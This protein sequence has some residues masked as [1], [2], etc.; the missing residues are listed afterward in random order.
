MKKVKILFVISIIFILA[1]LLC[2][3][4]CD[5]G[6]HIWYIVRVKHDVEYANGQTI[7]T[8]T[9]ANVHEGQPQG[10]HNGNVNITFYEDGTVVFNPLD[11]DEELHGTYTLKHNGFFK[12]TNFTITF[13]NGEKTTNGKAA[14]YYGGSDMEFEFRGV[15]YVFTD[16]ANG[17]TDKEEYIRRMEWLAHDVREK[18]NGLYDGYVTLENSGAKLTYEYFDKVKEI[19]L[20]QSGFMVTAVQ[21]TAEN[22]LIILDALKDGECICYT[23]DYDTREDEEPYRAVVYYVDPLADDLPPEEPRRYT[24]VEIVPELQYYIENPDS[25]LLKLFKEHIP[26]IEGE[27]N[28]HLYISGADNIDIWLGRFFD[29]SVTFIEDERPLD[30]DDQ[31]FRYIMKLSDKSGEHTNVIIRYECGMIYRNDKWYSIIGDFPTWYGGDPALSFSCKNY[32]MRIWLGGA[33]EGYYSINGLEFKEDK[34]QDYEY[35]ETQNICVLV[36]DIGEITVYD[37]T[38]FYYNGKYYIVTSEKNFSGLYS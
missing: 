2:S 29:G 12:D 32:S 22:E 17:S 11:S 36:G 20:Y 5:P 31:H 3:C 27:F 19:D 34:K 30:I 37:E 26:A 13:A 33:H 7:K 16:R 28:E 38:H 21:I 8:W 9:T 10:I 6:D 23:F 4:N 35:P 15:N 14:S 18:A 24:L 1:F 25:I